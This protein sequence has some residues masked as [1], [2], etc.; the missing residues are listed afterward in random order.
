MRQDLADQALS[1]QR[2]LE[3]NSDIELRENQYNDL[4]VVIFIFV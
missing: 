1:A 2:L 4:E 3:F